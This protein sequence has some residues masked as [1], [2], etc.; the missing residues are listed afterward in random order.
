MGRAIPIILILFVV[1]AAAIFWIYRGPT[2]PVDRI[3][4]VKQKAQETIARTEAHRYAPEA[5]SRIQRSL[6]DIDRLVDAEQKKLPFQRRYDVVVEQLDSVEREL[7]ELET[8]ARNNK[9]L[10]ADAL[11]QD[12]GTL[13]D[14]IAAIENELSDMP[15]AKGSRPALSG[16]RS[17]LAAIRR[18]L[19]E[20]DDLQQQDRFQQA[21][22]RAATAQADADRLLQEIRDTK[23]R[24][25]ALRQRS[26]P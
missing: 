8:L 9:Q 19:D 26:A 24:V 16:M 1:M 25:R 15:S 23:E 10:L 17:D 11:A 6:D 7:Q 22:Q 20:I 14:T 18:A 4:A 2:P 13:R 21:R 3:A 12:I 5:A